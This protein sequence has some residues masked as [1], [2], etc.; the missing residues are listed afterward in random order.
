MTRIQGVSRSQAGPLLRLTYRVARRKTA[1]LTQRETERMIEPV[2]VFGHVPKLL[3][4]WGALET[5]HEKVN[6]VEHRLK[7]LVQ[8]KA[9]TLAQCEYCIDIGSAVARNTGLSD[10]QLLAL[11][12][13]RESELFDEL[14]KLVL[15]YAVGMSSTP[16]DVSDELFASLRTHFD[17]AQLVELTMSIALENLRSRF[18]G[19][20]EIGSAG[21]TEGMVCAVPVTADTTIQAAA[22]STSAT[23]APAAAGLATDAASPRATP[24][25]ARIGV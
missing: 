18:N 8:L 2:E 14:E 20:F 23:R 25:G 6:R 4:G 24:S 19:A 5:A 9:A 11:A 17:D 12:H 10:A 22:A 15:D 13:Y 7:E 21:F 1:K 16:V 3:Y